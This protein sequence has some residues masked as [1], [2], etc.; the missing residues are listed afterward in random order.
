MIIIVVVVVV[1]IVQNNNTS[2]CYLPFVAFDMLGGESGMP[3]ST[4]PH[5][6]KHVV[7]QKRQLSHWIIIYL[8]SMR[9]LG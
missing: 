7:L 2:L 1:I 9:V 3:S 6:R 8:E 5:I 4:T